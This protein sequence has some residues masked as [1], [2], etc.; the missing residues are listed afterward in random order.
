VVEQALANQLAVILD[1][2]HYEEIMNSPRQHRER[3][4]AIWDQIARRYREAPDAV[5]FELLNEPY[6]TIAAAGYWNTLLAGAIGV[7]RQ[8]N[9]HRTIIVGPGNWNSLTNLPFLVVPKNERNVIVT[10]HYYSPFQFT[11]Q[12]AEWAEGS[13]AW[14]GT[15]W[16]G[17][18]AEKKAIR[19]DLERAANWGAKNR[20]PMFLGEFGAYSKADMGSR[21][22]W[23]SYIARQA[24]ELGIS[25]GYWEFGAGFGVYD[26]EARAWVEPIYT[27][28][29]PPEE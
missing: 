14:M 4:L 16:T 10:F 2:H 21:V 25:W 5:F 26:R 23:T 29:I 6:G 12:G 19:D 28:L 7:I 27:A 8:T 9:P 13:E 18:E 24:E 3:F 22:L 17:S 15:K 1:M 11:H 20:R